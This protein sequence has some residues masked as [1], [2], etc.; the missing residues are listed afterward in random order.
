MCSCQNPC[1]RPNGHECAGTG[2]NR[3]A[4]A[5]V[6][7]ERGKAYCEGGEVEPA[8]ARLPSSRRLPALLQ[9]GNPRLHFDRLHRPP[10]CFKDTGHRGA[11]LG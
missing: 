3:I 11:F 1:N 7:M 10:L 4:R 2:S 8:V 6:H 9:R 5:I